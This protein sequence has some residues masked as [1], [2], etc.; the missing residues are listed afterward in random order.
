MR[1]CPCLSFGTCSSRVSLEERK[2]TWVGTRL[3]R[4]SMHMASVVRERFI[5]LASSARVPAVGTVGT[6]HVIMMHNQH[7]LTPTWQRTVNRPRANTPT[8]TLAAALLQSLAA[9]KVH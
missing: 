4:A 1:Q 8:H 3:A 7:M 9:C 6:V 2:G 5:D